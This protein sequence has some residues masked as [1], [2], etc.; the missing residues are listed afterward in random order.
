MRHIPAIIILLCFATVAS[1]QQIIRSEVIADT[2]TGGSIGVGSDGGIVVAGP[3]MRPSL[4]DVIPY[5]AAVGPGGGKHIDRFLPVASTSPSRLLS[6]PDGGYFLV[7]LRVNNRLAEIGRLTVLRLDERGEVGATATFGDSLQLLTRPAVRTTVDGG[8]VV[9][10][11]SYVP[12]NQRG[13]GF[14]VRR[15]TA[16][17]ALAWERQYAPDGVAG[18]DAIRELSDGSLAVIGA[19]GGRLAVTKLDASGALLWS[20]CVGRDSIFT[21]MADVV[22]RPDG[23]LLVTAPQGAPTMRPLVMWID[24]ATGALERDTILAEQGLPK[25]VERAPNGGYLVGGM[26]FYLLRR[27]DERGAVQWALPAT[28]LDANAFELHDL[29]HLDGN[30]FAITFGTTNGSIHLAIIGDGP[31]GVEII[32]VRPVEMDLR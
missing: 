16:A 22:E 23:G 7:G 30:R 5:F 29:R 20:R 3:T 15:Y 28:L 10:T 19:C 6:G 8:F 17:G 14:T 13:P 31:S 4:T 18:A 12:V 9:G 2:S 11:T 25:L 1:A 21:A 27:I 26:G 32:D 24:G